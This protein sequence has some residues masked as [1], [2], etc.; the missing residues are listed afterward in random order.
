[1]LKTPGDF[2][3]SVYGGMQEWLIKTSNFSTCVSVHESS[4]A[5]Q[6]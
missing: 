3:H 5:E 6:H 1:M 2:K 4:F